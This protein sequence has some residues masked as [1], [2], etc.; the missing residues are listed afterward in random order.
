[1][2]KLLV[3]VLFVDYND[4]LICIGGPDFLEVVDNE[5]SIDL[6]D[7]QICPTGWKNGIQILEIEENENEPGTYEKGTWR[8]ITDAE[9]KELKAEQ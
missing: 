8:A 2:H 9:L 3:A 4:T 6:N 1:M 7:W 5:E